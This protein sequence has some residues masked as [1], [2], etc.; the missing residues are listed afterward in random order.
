[1]AKTKAELLNEEAS[2]KN[3]DE[4]R[5]K[6]NSRKARRIDSRPFTEI[7]SLKIRSRS[8]LKKR[9]NRSKGGDIALF[10]F[11]AI[12]GVLSILPLLLIVNNAFK[13]LDEIFRFPPTIFVRNPT[14]SNFADLGVV[15]GTS[16]VPFSRYLF[17]TILVTVLGTFGHVFVASMC[18]Y[19]LAKYRVP[20]GM[21]INGLIIY[22]LM[23][24]G[25]V[26]ATPHYIILNSLGLIDTYW[27]IILPVTAG[28]LGLYLMRQFM[29]GVPMEYIESAKLDGASDLKIYWSI[30]MPIVKPAWVTLIILDF[31]SLW[32]A[33][34]AT[35]IYREDYKMLSY[36]INQIAT[37]GVARTGTLNAV[38]LIMITVPI[39]VFIFSQTNIM[40]TMAQSGMK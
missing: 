28:S 7:S 3:I 12:A 31:Q 4:I 21:F 14:L 20:G 16:L 35:T 5:E 29:V 37:A 8:K 11:L 34:G 36:A 10:A 19:V 15:L 26:T 2:Q 1:M 33:Y 30:V 40:D 27:S 32:G 6:E 17:N 18:A 38:S 13:P 9:I 22:S 24:P 25:S 39:A 23:F